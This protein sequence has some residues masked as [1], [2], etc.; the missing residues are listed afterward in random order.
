MP[1]GGKSVLEIEKPQ[2]HEVV[3]YILQGVTQL[4]CEGQRRGFVLTN[5]AGKEVSSHMQ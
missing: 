5:K 4:E 3:L 2:G 1:G